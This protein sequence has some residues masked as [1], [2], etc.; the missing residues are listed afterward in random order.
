MLS[1]AL[2]RA[3]LA[4]MTIDAVFAVRMAKFNFTFNGDTEVNWNQECESDPIS[5]DASEAQDS[6]A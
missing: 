6:V 2:S 1:S 5:D 3:S 4:A